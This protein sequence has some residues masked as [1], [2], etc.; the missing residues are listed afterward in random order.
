MILLLILLINY[1][2]FYTL[3]TPVSKRNTKFHALHYII[4][5]TSYTILIQCKLYSYLYTIYQYTIVHTSLNRFQVLGRVQ[6][7]MTHEQ[8]RITDLIFSPMILMMVLP[9]LFLFVMPKLLEYQGPDISM[10]SFLVNIVCKL[11][12]RIY[13]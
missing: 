2:I 13:S 4:Y 3:Y 12:F 7:F 6:Y 1:V 11:V 9:L 8:S 5:C 10:V